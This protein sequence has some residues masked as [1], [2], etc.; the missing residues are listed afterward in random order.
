[1][2]AYPESAW[3]VLSRI[4]EPAMKA[5]PADRREAFFLKYHEMIAKQGGPAITTKPR[6]WYGDPTIV[7]LKLGKSIGVT[8]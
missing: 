8:L 4:E 5:L 1:M 6:N 3:D 2:C 7:F